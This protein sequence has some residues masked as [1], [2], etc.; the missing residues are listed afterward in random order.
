MMKVL[1]PA[2]L[3]IFLA[4]APAALATTAD[5][6]AGACVGFRVAQFYG[7]SHPSCEPDRLGQ[8]CLEA[9]VNAILVGTVV[10]DCST[11]T[12]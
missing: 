3:I 9:R 5:D 12:L 6:A 8:R 10:G 11:I 2:G 4:L 1:L 7:S